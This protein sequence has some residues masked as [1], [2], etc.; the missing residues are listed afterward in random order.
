M[1]RALREAQFMSLQ[2]QMRPH[3]LFNALNTIS[4]SALLEEA[5]STE[6]LALGLGR[7]MRYSI[8]AGG[9]SVPLREELDVLREYLEFQSIRFG[10]RLAWRIDADERLGALPIPRFTLQPLVENAVRHGIE[11]LERGGAVRV[12]A[13]LRRGRVRIVV[14][15]NGAG[16]GRE[17]AAALRAAGGDSAEPPLGVEGSGLGIANIKLRLALRYGDQARLCVSSA[18]GR[19]TVVRI[20]MPAPDALGDPSCG[21]ARAEALRA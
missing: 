19:G 21:E 4:R 10:K 17:R 1:G 15:D 13:A 20:S 16:M 5:P 11:P 9:G 14:A 2:D 7:L 12:R 3:F 6:R 18:P 8:G